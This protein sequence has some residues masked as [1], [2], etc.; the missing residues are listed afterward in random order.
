[1]NRILK[2]LVITFAVACGIGVLI[3][4]LGW[5]LQWN[6]PIHFSNSFFFAGAILVVLG[7]LSVMGSYTIRADFGVLFSQSAGNMNTLERSQRWIADTMQAYNSFILLLL[8]GIYLIG[9]AI[10]IPNIF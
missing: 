4:A 10:A 2:L 9:F 3:A 1:M 5:L 7:I 8:V 6:S